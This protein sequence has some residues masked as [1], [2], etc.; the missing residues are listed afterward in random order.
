VEYSTN[1]PRV[2]YE[3]EHGTHECRWV[4]YDIAATNPQIE[5]SN[6]MDCP[7][8]RHNLHADP[9]PLPNFNDAKG[10]QDDQLQVFFLGFGSRRLVDR[11]L[12]EVGDMGLTAEVHRLCTFWKL[13]DGL[14]KQRAE[15][16]AE[17]LLAEESYLVTAHYLTCTRGPSHIGEQI[18]NFPTEETTLLGQRHYPSPAPTRIPP[19]VTSQGPA[20]RTNSPQDLQGK[21]RF[22]CKN[23]AGQ[24]TCCAYC[25]SCGEADNHTDHIC[26]QSC[27]WCAEEH[28]SS[29]CKDLH[30]ACTQDECFIP[31]SHPNHG[32]ICHMFDYGADDTDCDYCEAVAN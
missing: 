17:L 22:T 31:I 6:R 18:F 29:F 14:Y 19:I 20:D 9:K 27:I 16:E 1:T 7:V 24:C 25:L 30:I 23:A 12:G 3:N 2:L 8:Y 4:W 15:L 26:H 28:P 10:F 13:Q 21:V 32:L 11:A 5:G